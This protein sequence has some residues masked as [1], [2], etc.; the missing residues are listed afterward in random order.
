MEFRYYWSIT[1]SIIVKANSKEEAD[2]KWRSLPVSELIEDLDS[3]NL[4]DYDV[5]NSANE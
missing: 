5:E 4:D 2:R 3:I 1:S